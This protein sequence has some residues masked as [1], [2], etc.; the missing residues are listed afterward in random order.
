MSALSA[1]PALRRKILVIDDEP[2]VAGVYARY[3]KRKGCDVL[4]MNSGEG[5]ADR[6]SQFC[7]DVVLLDLVMPGI[8]GMEVLR[9]IKR[10]SPDVKVVIITAVKDEMM[11][12]ICRKLGASDYIVKPIELSHLDNKVL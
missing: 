4:E 1:K 9:Q 5:L 6:V 11:L 3:L 8:N 10:F 2:V 7:P 12:E